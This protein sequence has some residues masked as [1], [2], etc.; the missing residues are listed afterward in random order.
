M[1]ITLTFDHGPSEVTPDV[2]DTLKRHDLSAFFF[3]LGKQLAHPEYRV[4]SERAVAEGHRVGNHTYSHGTAFGDM[5]D[6]QE[7]IDELVSTQALIGD[8][9][10][11]DPLFR[12]TGGGGIID[13]RLLNA[14]AVDCLC[15]NRFTVALW[16]SVPRDWVD[17]DTWPETALADVR[18]RDWSVLVVHD[19]PTGAMRQLDRFIGA[20]LDEGATFSSD[21]P[22]DLLP[23]VK[24]I[25]VQDLAPITGGVAVS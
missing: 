16:N 11:A 12:P 4:H 23:I 2:L 22:N 8:L 20:A 24:G 21:L 7:A 9:A 3:L 15:E 6:P 17:I 13:H 19:V 18:T 1:K 5:T 10:G 25:K 14:R